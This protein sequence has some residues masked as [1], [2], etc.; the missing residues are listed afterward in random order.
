MH[1]HYAGPDSGGAVTL[2]HS[3]PIPK[4]SAHEFEGSFF[5]IGNADRVPD[6]GSLGTPVLVRKM[7]EIDLDSADFE[8][9]GLHDHFAARS[10]QCCLPT[11]PLASAPFYAP[12]CECVLRALIRYFRLSLKVAR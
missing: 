3:A 5:K 11:H 2:L 1:L 7:N 12:L 10:V 8:R 4:E 6:I 9:L